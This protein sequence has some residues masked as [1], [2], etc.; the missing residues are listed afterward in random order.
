MRKVEDDLRVP[1]YK[2]LI[3]KEECKL[4]EAEKAWNGML[5]KYPK[6]WLS[7]ACYADCMAKL[8]RYDEAV[9]YYRKAFELQPKP[10]YTDAFQAIAHIEEIRGNYH[11]A[12]E[13]RKN[14]IKLLQEEW[15]I[16]LGE[17]VDFPKREINRLNKLK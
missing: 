16:S 2:G 13:A 15:N 9:I 17:T 8:C 6:N 4:E 12:I 7:N 10:R 3:L 14:Q 11:E 1:L 5:E